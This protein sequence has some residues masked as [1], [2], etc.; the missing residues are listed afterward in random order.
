MSPTILLKG[1]NDLGFW[2]LVEEKEYFIPFSDYPGFRDSSINQILN[3][4]FMP[5]SQLHWEEL[6]VDIELQALV[7]PDSYPLAFKA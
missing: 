6:D 3:I 2:V 1:I 7:Q 5:P 4:R